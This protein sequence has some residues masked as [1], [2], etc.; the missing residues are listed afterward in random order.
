MFRP[1]TAETTWA[2]IANRT[3]TG[4][5]EAG[6]NNALQI[7]GNN[8]W[9]GTNATKVY[10]STDLGLT[11]TSGATTGTVN[12][13]AVHYNTASVGLAGGTA[14]VLSTNGE[15]SYSAVTNPGTAGNING[16]DGAGTDWWA[17][18]SGNTIY[19]STDGATTWTN[20]HVPNFSIPA[21]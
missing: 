12:S 16:I 10:K 4:G 5:T 15:T 14:M 18:R 8:M 13:Y 20:A 9:F 17:I 19:R 11:W 1:P 7:I 2:R 21:Y 3:C 6:W